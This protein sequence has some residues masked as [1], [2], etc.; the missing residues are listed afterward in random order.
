MV[1]TAIGEWSEVGQLVVRTLVLYLVALTVFR[2]MGKRTLAKMGPFDFAVIIMIGEA[3]AIGMEDAKTPL[4]NAVAITVALGA[5]QYLLTWLNVRFRW[6]ERVT[7]GTP[8]E[9]IRDGQV[10]AAAMRRERIS[11]AD[12]QMEL[13]QQE[14]QSPEEVKRALLEPT[15]E[16]S[17]EKASGSGGAGRKGG[18]A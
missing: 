16:I 11:S 6:L 1:G 9:L 15:G 10:D 5:L 3:V 13:R 14:V 7:Q 18:D 2:A 12:L 8:T 17:V 4:I